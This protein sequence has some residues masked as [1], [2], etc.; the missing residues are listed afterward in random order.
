MAKSKFPKFLWVERV[1][2]KDESYLLTHDDPSDAA[3]NTDGGTFGV[4]EF[5]ETQELSLR[6]VSGKIVKAK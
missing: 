1:Q 5:K 2:D 4:Y 3:K 6:V